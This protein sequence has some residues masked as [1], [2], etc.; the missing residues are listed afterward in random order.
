VTAPALAVLRWE[1]PPNP[2]KDWAGGRKP[3]S[4][5]DP[6]AA[7]LRDEPRRWAV[8]FEGGRN[9]AHGVAARIRQARMASF[10]PLG[11]FEVAT[12]AHAGQVT[13]YARYIGEIS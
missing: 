10:L 11:A 1:E 9:E 8:V 13:V 4:R 7:A 12:R 6:I 3:G 5:F 2:K